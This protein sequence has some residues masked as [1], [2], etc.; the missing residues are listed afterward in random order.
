MSS[1]VALVVGASRGIGA[2]TACELGRRGFHVALASRD[3][4]A[5]HAV[6]AQIRTGGGD[7]FVVPTDVTDPGATGAMVAATVEHYGRLDAAFNNAGSGHVPKPFAQLSI[8]DI[9]ASIS[10]NLRGILAAM[11]YELRAML[12]RGG[13][14]IVNM[15]STA[16]VYGVR[17]MG[18]YSATK[19]ALVGA[20]KSAA[21]DHAADNVRI[22]V[23]APGPI[24]TDRIAAL[25]AERRAHVTRGV[26]LGRIGR[27]EEVASVVA[28]LLSDDASYVTGAVIPIDGGLLAGH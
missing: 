9:D 20:T 2:A 6:A 22:N 7:A 1:K 3:E 21:L 11:T 8:D 12:P 14:A 26:P 17:G 16:G 23:V 19:H 4:R 18:A 13:G 25:P 5:L 27:P 15:A 24:E 10:I 28:W